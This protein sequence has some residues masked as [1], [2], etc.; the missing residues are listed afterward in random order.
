MGKV[1]TSPCD[2]ITQSESVYTAVYDE[3]GEYDGLALSSSNLLINVTMPDGRVMYCSVYVTYYGE[4][5]TETIW[6]GETSRREN[7]T[8]LTECRIRCDVNNVYSNGYNM[9]DTVYV[10]TS[11]ASEYDMEQL[12]SY[13]R[14]RALT[15]SSCCADLMRTVFYEVV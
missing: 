6:N 7:V 4:L 14:D 2:E 15:P 12:W 10:F 11:L 3:N 1:Q 13:F 9:F 5:T 8:Y